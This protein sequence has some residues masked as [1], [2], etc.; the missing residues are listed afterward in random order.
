[1]FR[2]CIKFIQVK[3]LKC[4]VA[5]IFYANSQ[6]YIYSYTFRIKRTIHTFD[7]IENMFFTQSIMRYF[8]VLQK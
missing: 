6:T 7:T 8:M 4:Y 5:Y 3:P 1:M 2:D